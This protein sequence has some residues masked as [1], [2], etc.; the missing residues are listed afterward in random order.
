MILQHGICLLLQSTANQ[1]LRIPRPVLNTVYNK[2]IEGENFYG[3]HEILLTVN[4]K[5]SMKFSYLKSS[6]NTDLAMYMIAIWNI[7]TIGTQ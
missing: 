3:C 6:W 2:T 7:A 1:M 5:F 4:V